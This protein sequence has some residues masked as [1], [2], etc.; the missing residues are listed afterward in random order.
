MKKAIG[1]GFLLALCLAVGAAAFAG[2]RGH[3]FGKPSPERIYKM[4]SWH[5]DDALDALEVDSVQRG[6]IKAIQDR[7]FG[8]WRAM[9]DK[10]KTHKKD[11]L[12]QWRSDNPDPAAF[13]AHAAEHADQ[14]RALGQKVADA[15][16]ELHGVLT[17]EQRGRVADLIEEH[18]TEK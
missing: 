18:L 5:V 4:L 13:R 3:H 6:R 8:E 14:M 9:H 17:P 7:L 1:Y 12:S 16:V 2:C 15:V 11:L 10:S